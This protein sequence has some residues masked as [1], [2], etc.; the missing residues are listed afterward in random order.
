MFKTLFKYLSATFVAAVVNSKN[1]PAENA[2]RLL[3]SI[4]DALLD[5][6]TK[7][8]KRNSNIAQT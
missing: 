7:G 2:M 4:S 5:V 1:I 8:L 6:L 3:N